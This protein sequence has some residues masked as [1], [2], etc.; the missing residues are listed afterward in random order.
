MD[1]SIQVDELHKSGPAFPCEMPLDD[2]PDVRI[3]FSGMS[4]RDYFAGLIAP[5]L[6]DAHMGE[7]DINDVARW[8]YMHADAMLRARR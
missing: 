2:H 8:A 5:A 1:E 6:V 4:L 3:R 7:A